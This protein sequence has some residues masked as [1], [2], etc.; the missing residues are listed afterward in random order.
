MQTN[1]N[2]H[3][4]A[5]GDVDWWNP[6]SLNVA[7]HEGTTAALHASGEDVKVQP[8]MLYLAVAYTAPEIGIV[9]V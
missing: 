3:I 4:Y 1:V 6:A 8:S 5:A 2:A 9:S 7:S